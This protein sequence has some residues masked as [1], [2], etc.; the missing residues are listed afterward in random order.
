MT[1]LGK[2]SNITGTNN[3]VRAAVVVLTP[4]LGISGKAGRIRGEPFWKRRLVGQITQ[5]TGRGD[6]SKLERREKQQ[7]TRVRGLT[8]IELKHRVKGKGASV[9]IEELRQ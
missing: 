5:L 8:Q 2:N 9:V 1:C 7:E 3:L 6:I 4:N